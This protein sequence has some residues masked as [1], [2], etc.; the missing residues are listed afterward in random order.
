VRRG[1]GRRLSGLARAGTSAGLL[2]LMMFLGGLVLWVGLPV[3]WFWIG[4]QIQGATGSLGAAVGAVLA[5]FVLSV[6]AFVPLL[7]W[8]SHRYDEAR[9]ARGLDPF[10]SAALEGVL[11]VSAVIAV[12]LFVVWFFFLAGAEPLPLNLPAP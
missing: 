2:L 10:G 6:V 9:V 8:L 3:A 1:G 7:S 4:G 11:V 12:A 5:G